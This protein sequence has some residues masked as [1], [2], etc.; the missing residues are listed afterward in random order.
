MD[1]K[2]HLI[3][4]FVGSKSL[5]TFIEFGVKTFQPIILIYRRGK[6]N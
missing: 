5:G 2:L 3:E 4:L 1:C 6:F